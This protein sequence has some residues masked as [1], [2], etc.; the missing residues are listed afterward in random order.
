MITVKRIFWSVFV[1][2]CIMACSS[3][4]DDNPEG[5]NSGDGY[6]RAA[7]LTNL[8]DNIII[9]AFQEL[10]NKLTTL[11]SDK[12]TFTATPNQSNLTALRG[13]W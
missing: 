12:D 6:N 13:S 1:L 2:V 5:G 8:A 11:K 4:S 10:D 9:P 7:L 3:S